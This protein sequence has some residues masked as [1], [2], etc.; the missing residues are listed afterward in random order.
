M[1]SV[2]QHVGLTLPQPSLTS[3]VTPK[4]VATLLASQ[5]LYGNGGE[6]AV[7]MDTG[8][9]AGGATTGLDGITLRLKAG[10]GVGAAGAGEGRLGGEVDVLAGVG[11]GAVGL[12]EL[13]AC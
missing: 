12:G 7:A 4:T 11:E 13:D 3:R 5:S 2:D 8:E 1:I 10:V 6:T 9:G